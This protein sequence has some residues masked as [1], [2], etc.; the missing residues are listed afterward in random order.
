MELID[1]YTFDKSAHVL[2]GNFEA[3]YKVHGLEDLRLHVNLAGEYSD[4]G[5]YTNN[6]PFSTYG[7]YFGGVGENVEKKYNVMLSSLSY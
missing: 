2:L 5:E 3:D 7:F 4:G 1:H 6:N